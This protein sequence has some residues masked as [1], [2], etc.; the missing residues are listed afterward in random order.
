M[1]DDRDAASAMNI[2]QRCF[3]GETWT[4][5]FP[6]RNKSGQRFSAVTT[7]SPFYD[8]A[9][10]LVGIISLTSKSAPYLHPIISL[11]KLKAKKQGETNSSPVSSFVSKLGLESSKGAVLSKPG[12]DSHQPVQAVIASKISDMVSNK[13]MPKMQA[14]DSNGG[15]TL[16][17]GV[18]GAA[19]SEPRDDASASG[20]SIQRGVRSL[21]VIREVV[22]GHQFQKSRS[23]SSRTRF[24]WNCL[25]RFLVW[26]CC[27]SKIVLQRRLAILKKLFSLLDKRGVV[28]WEL[29]TEKIP[30]ETLNSMQRLEIPK[31]IDPFW[32]SLMQSCWHRDT[33]LKVQT[34]IPRTDGEARRSAWRL[35][36]LLAYE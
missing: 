1:V 34:H 22:C 11:A 10:S 3:N 13:V 20:A 14:G 2:A 33:K 15:A 17:E 35:K 26:I 9:G 36:G 5:E 28:P 6:V 23:I 29:A 32:I 19:L 30:W 31:D 8:D 7:C 12:P 18:F 25:P 16:S 24:M 27:S 4:G 21:A